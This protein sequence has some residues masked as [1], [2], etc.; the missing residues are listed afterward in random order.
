VRRIVLRRAAGFQ[1]GYQQE[2]LSRSNDAVERLF[3]GFAQM[4]A[5]NGR[6]GPRD[7]ANA[8]GAR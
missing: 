8:I 3:Y 2:S 4:S 6:S 7:A 5:A 1:T